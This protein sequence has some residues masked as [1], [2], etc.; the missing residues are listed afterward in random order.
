MRNL[1]LIPLFSM[2]K[3]SLIKVYTFSLAPQWY[4]FLLTLLQQYLLC[5][6]LV[7]DIKKNSY[8]IYF[9]ISKV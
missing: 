4:F 6:L 9:F 2:L 7:F 5:T 3:Y 8:E 1:G